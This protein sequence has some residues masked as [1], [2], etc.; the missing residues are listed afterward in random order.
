MNSSLV[1][2]GHALLQY[3]G[4]ITER[5]RVVWIR[6]NEGSDTVGIWVGGVG[7]TESGNE[8]SR[9]G[10][11]EAFAQDFCVRRRRVDWDD[12]DRRAEVE[13]VVKTI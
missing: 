7:M 4:G 11:C 8:G 12:G 10:V 9:H 3:G 6:E 2:P 1:A 13:V 5:K